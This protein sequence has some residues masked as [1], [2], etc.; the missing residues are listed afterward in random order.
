[1]NKTYLSTS[2]FLPWFKLKDLY[3]IYY[4]LNTHTHLN[5]RL[6]AVA[7]RHKLQCDPIIMFMVTASTGAV[8]RNIQ[9]TCG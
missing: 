7:E 4:L 3:Y 9:Y 2:T 8:C 6:A 1:M 5:Q